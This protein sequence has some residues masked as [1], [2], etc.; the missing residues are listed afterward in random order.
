MFTEYVQYIMQRLAFYEL[1]NDKEPYYGE[2]KGFEGVWAQGESLKDCEKNL[3]EV[4]E[5]WLILK[6]RK[7]KFLPTTRKYDLNALLSK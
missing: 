1:M 6:I 5:E 2:I 7:G 4:L 3:Q